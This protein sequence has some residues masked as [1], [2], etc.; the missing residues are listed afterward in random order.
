MERLPL[1]VAS[2]Q[3]RDPFFERSVIVLWHY[4]EG[5]AAGVIVNRA[6]DQVLED[7][8]DDPN[9]P[10]LGAS[11][12]NPVVLGG[13]V[14]HGSGT[15]VA[16]T[17]HVGD[18]GWSPAPGLGVTRSH[19]VLLDLVRRQVPFVL[20]LGYAGWGP[21]QLD[22]ELEDGGWI[23]TDAT[24]ELVFGGDLE[25]L[26]ERALATVGFTTDTVWMKPIEA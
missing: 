6:T 23:W 20:C 16:R 18:D 9:A 21:G 11:A 1:L 17:D 14:E 24:P 12:L 8:L 10:D 15:V 25:D 5:G 22:R 2:P 19:E 13:P 3:M 7:V 4:D 26:Y